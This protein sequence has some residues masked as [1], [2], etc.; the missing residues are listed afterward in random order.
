[1]T[2]STWLLEVGGV[3][4][5]GGKTWMLH[6]CVAPQPEQKRAWTGSILLHCAKPHPPHPNSLDERVHRNL[7]V[8]DSP[9]GTFAPVEKVSRAPTSPPAPLLKLPCQLLCCGSS[10]VCVPCRTVLAYNCSRDYP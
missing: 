10:R 3:A 8:A 5:L 6:T 2:V 7:F 9:N 1:M 4:Q